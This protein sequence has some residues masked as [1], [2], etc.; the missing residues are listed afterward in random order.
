MILCIDIGNTNVVT[1]VWDG[2]KYVIEKRV[3]SIPGTKNTLR[4]IDFEK[5]SKII[6]SSVVPI[7]L[8]EYIVN[9]KKVYKDSIFIVDSKNCNLDL[10]VDFPDEVGADRICNSF[11]GKHFFGTP[12]VIVDFGSATTYDVIDKNGSFIGGAISPGIDVSANHLIKRTAL[13]KKTALRFPRE[14]IGKNT[15]TNLQ[16][17]IMYGGLESVNGMLTR[18]KNQMDFE[19]M[20]VILT[21]GLSS[22][23][24]PKLDRKH[25]LAPQ[26]TLDGMRLIESL[27]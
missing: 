18:I 23:I 26:L 1:A 6:I 16:S 2:N 15:A 27:N 7:L 4:H 19:N 3:N 11:A 25:H 10:K 22:L 13:L 12:I 8:N 14:V 24:S 17:G 9:I 20:N 21:G 5:I